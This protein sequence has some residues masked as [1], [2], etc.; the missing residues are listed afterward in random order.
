MLS[1]LKCLFFKTIVFK[2]MKVT[3]YLLKSEYRLNCSYMRNQQDLSP[4]R[5]FHAIKRTR[6]KR[7]LKTNVKN[8]IK[9]CEKGESKLLKP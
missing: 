4:S 2:A 9:I 7:E 8:S 3:N 5:K 6:Q 1:R